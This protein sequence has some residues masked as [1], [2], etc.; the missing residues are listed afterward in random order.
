VGKLAEAYVDVG[1]NLKPMQAGLGR[2]RSML[3]SF[4]SRAITVGIGGAG[5]VAGGLLAAAK[6]SADLGES[7]SKVRVTF[8]RDAQ[9]M[10]DQAD[11][12]ADRFGVVKQEALDA[13]AGFGL[14]GRAAGL[15]TAASAKLGQE[16]VQLGLDI[17]SYHNL[18][19]G[20][21]FDKLRS[22]M[23]GESEP[24]KPLGFLLSEDAVKAEALAMG[25]TRVKRELTEQEKV[26]ARISLIRKQA[27]T[28]GAIGDL[29]RTADSNANQ[30]RKLQGELENAAVAFGDNL[31]EA[32]RDGIKL[33]HELA[34]VIK[35]ATGK[36]PGKLVGDEIRDRINGSRVA[37]KRGPAFVLM[38]QAN[39][40]LNLVGLGDRTGNLQRAMGERAAEDL[41][42]PLNA[43]G[44][45]GMMTN[46]QGKRDPGF[47]AAQRQ[48]QQADHDRRVAAAAKRIKDREDWKK[49]HDRRPGATAEGNGVELGLRGVARNFLGQI[50]S[51][52]GAT[53]PGAAGQ[54]AAN[55]FG[56]NLIPGVGV[57]G[58]A[59]RLI[60]GGLVLA[61]RVADAAR[62]QAEK[63]PFQSQAFSDPA[64]FARSA[65]QSALSD[66][67]D[68]KAKQLQALDQANDKLGEAKTVLSDILTAIR[69]QK[70]GAILRGP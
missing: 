65:I 25:L 63:G 43:P 17:A 54:G 35:E 28:Q 69:N 42:L 33:A 27:A 45:P 16:M 37:L 41:G 6:K 51:I 67:D 60:Q 36:E 20:D 62:A 23:A 14:M 9:G 30:L 47:L 31:Q 32:L 10:I 53:A 68:A 12:L 2:A 39:Q 8:G 29:S 57:G 21:A 46:A 49:D 1:A 58:A 44:I 50:Q 48:A 64:D 34:G 61:N 7:L 38:D 26:V 22:G 40:L 4:A 55:Q 5:G 13:A 70:P 15:S 3:T 19:N 52:A 66:P 56:R 18:A 11:D 59:G 24:L